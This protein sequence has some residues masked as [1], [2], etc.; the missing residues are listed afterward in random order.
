MTNRNQLRFFRALTGVL[1]SRGGLRAVRAVGGARPLD[2]LAL[3]LANKTCPEAR[4]HLA[5]KMLGLRLRL[6][7]ELSAGFRAFRPGTTGQLLLPSPVIV[8]N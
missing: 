6:S 2:A 5:G 7:R 8:P 1:N 3:S 4:F